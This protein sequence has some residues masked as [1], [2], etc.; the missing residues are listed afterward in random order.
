VRTV[1]AP[2]GEFFGSGLGP[3]RVRSLMFA[4]NPS[5][6]GWLTS[7]WPM[8]FSSSAQLELYNGSRTSVSAGDLILVSARSPSW[9]M[10][11]GNHGAAGYFHAVGH[12]GPTKKGVWWNFLSARGSGLFVGVTQTMQGRAQP[13]YL[14]GNERAYV[15]GGRR[16]AIQGTGTEDFYR[17]GWYF[18]NRLFTLPLTGYTGRSGL[19]PGC[20]AGSCNTAYRL[21]IA[22]AVPF[23]RSIRYE[24]EHG[25]R[26]SERA[27]YSSTAYWYQRR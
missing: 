4:M 12:R 27:I 26:N 7:W 10:A 5:P 23:T 16:P 1:D 19:E 14:E 21:M 2:V 17:G 25:V 22:D 24:I 13:L 3:A 20:P 18:L 15:D 9:R 11:L 8:P 6:S